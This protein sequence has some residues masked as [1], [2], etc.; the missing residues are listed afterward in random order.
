MTPVESPLDSVSAGLGDGDTGSL[1]DAASG[2]W[3]VV[4][5]EVDGT[6]DEE[7]VTDVA[8]LEVV[9]GPDEVVDVSE[10]VVDDAEVVVLVSDSGREEA[11]I[12]K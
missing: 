8:E 6:A 12:Q 2:A 9:E 3:E 7:V 11:R 5:E 1:F 10:E 4:V